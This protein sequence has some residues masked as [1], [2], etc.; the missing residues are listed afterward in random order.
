MKWVYSYVFVSAPGSY[1]MG[2][3]NNLFIIIT[4]LENSLFDMETKAS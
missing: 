4:E 1:K 3:Q 2:H